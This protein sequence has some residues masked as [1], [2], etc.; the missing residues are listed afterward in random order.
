MIRK[1]H[2]LLLVAASAAMAAPFS[3]N[4]SDWYGP[5]KFFWEF[6]PNTITS[7]TPW[8]MLLYKDGVHAS[9]AVVETVVTPLKR[10]GDEWGVAGVRLYRDSKHFWQFAVVDVPEE[11]KP[12][13]APLYELGEQYESKWPCRDNYTVEK[14]VGEKNVWQYGT[15]YRLRLEA[16][17]ER[18]TAT[19]ST[20]DG[21]IVFQ[22]V[23][24]LGA[25]ATR[26]V[27]PGLF[28]G[29]M[30]ARFEQATGSWEQVEANPP[31]DDTVF[32]IRPASDFPKYYCNSFVPDIQEEATGFFYPKQLDDGRWWMIDP[33]G[34]GF[35]VFGIDHCT[36]HGHYCEALKAHPH[37][38]KND[39]KF[40]SRKEWA[41][42]ALKY[43]KDWGFNLVTAGISSELIH[44]GIP[45]TIFMGLGGQF[46][47]LGPEFAIAENKGVPGSAFPN[48]FHPR[49]PEFCRFIISRSCMSSVNDPWL[50]GVF[51]D[52]ELRWWGDGKN[53]KTGLFNIAFELDPEHSAKQAA[54]EILKEKCNGDLA[55]FNKQWNLKLD[56]FDQLPKLTILPQ[57]TEEQIEIKRAFLALVAEK[58]F[59]TVG[60]IFRE[61]DPNHLLLGSRFA[62][63]S[64]HDEV[65]WKAAGKYCDIVTWNQYGYVDLNLEA[66]FSSK[67]P[68]GQP[69]VEEFHKVY[70]WTQKPTM[71][72][73][74]SFPAL[75][76]GLP[77][78]HGAGQ[79]FHTQ[80][81]R[82]KATEIYARALLAIP[83]M[84]GYDYFMWV[85][86]PALGISAKFPEN[87]NYGLVNED[88][89]PYP[90]ITSM[91]AKLQ[92]NPGEARRRE[93]PVR[94]TFEIVTKGKLYDQY[95]AK[96]PTGEQ[97]PVFTFTIGP[98]Q[99]S[100]KASNGKLNLELLE[101]NAQ[102]KLSLGKQH[103]GNFNVMLWHDNESGKNTWT[104]VNQCDS[105]TISAGQNAMEINVIARKGGK[106]TS[107]IEDQLTQRQFK[108][109]YKFVLLP[110]ADWFLSEIISVQP[111]D[112]LALDIKGFFFRLYPAFQVLPPPTHKAPNL[113]NDNQK[114]AWRSKDDKRFLGVAAIQNFDI[115]LHYWITD[116]TALHPDA[117][118]RVKA[119][120]PAGESYKLET[121]LYIMNYLGFGDVEDIVKIE[122]RLQQLDLP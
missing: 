32:K 37:K 55:T 21:T 110:E 1:V 82:T 101:E 35:V 90:E 100:F 88:L 119:S 36:Y 49:F 111:I 4:P 62:G 80:T 79:R 33:L 89:E 72:T 77:C 27:R 38:L 29:K 53:S 105:V 5:T 122:K 64:G 74:W 51:I 45:H 115:T 65:I 120:V 30:I 58:Y 9:N 67:P 106:T 15:P 57:E 34:R 3:M 26:G 93:P 76:S 31:E 47:A 40:A 91:F 19:A 84:V 107:A 8:G 73:E 97:N 25:N 10:D 13:L 118:R 102:V 104:D 98:Q 114:C 42:V 85:D 7:G 43:L 109:H 87:S 16:N 60:T 92:K 52:N 39:K 20:L 78:T 6:K 75:D 63:M 94:K 11:H 108:I 54:V 12:N 22:K 116:D 23:L 50:F 121:P 103:F 56:S 17:V 81:Q 61:I 99:K 24:K 41:D 46:S 28:T 69:L 112:D 113:W 117:F 68:T 2:V 48:V 71:L 14:V 18:V 96:K 95:L 66:A 83:S 70:D 86:E 59:G 44:Q